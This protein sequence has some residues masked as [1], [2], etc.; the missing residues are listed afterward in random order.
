MP[1]FVVGLVLLF[2]LKKWLVFFLLSEEFEPVSNLF[3]GQMVGDFFKALSLI[4]GM[5]F[6]AKKNG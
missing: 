1:F 6:Y 4:L 3:L 5:Q 2:I